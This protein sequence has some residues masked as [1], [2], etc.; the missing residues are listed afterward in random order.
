MPTA[1]LLR[2]GQCKRLFEALHP[3]PAFA[4]TFDK[5]GVSAQWKMHLP[6]CSLGLPDGASN[7]A[8][9]AVDCFALAIGVGAPLRVLASKRQRFGEIAFRRPSLSDEPFRRHCV[10]PFCIELG[11][12]I[13]LAAQ[14]A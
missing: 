12:R 11:G 5:G 7:F 8:R 6:R 9:V 4:T 2:E 13:V 1:D 3:N 14:Q 10:E